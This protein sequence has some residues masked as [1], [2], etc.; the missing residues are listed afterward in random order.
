MTQLKNLE[1]LANIKGKLKICKTL[2]CLH[3]DT[4]DIV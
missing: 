3:S 4:N 2:Q 1:M